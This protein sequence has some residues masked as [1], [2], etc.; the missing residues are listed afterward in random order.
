MENYSS[1]IYSSSRNLS[2]VE[3]IAMKDLTD[4]IKFDDILFDDS[5]PAIV[6]EPETWAIIEIHNPK[7]E[8]EVYFAYVIIS[9]DGDKYYTSSSAFWNS[10]TDIEREMEGEPFSIKVYKKESTNYKGKYFITCSI[11]LA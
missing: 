4:A 10:F 2:P 7:A 11:I 3:R 6:I 5:T 1:K 9:K 8:K